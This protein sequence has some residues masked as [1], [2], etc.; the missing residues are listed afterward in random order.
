MGNKVKSYKKLK[1]EES[2]TVM[3]LKTSVVIL[4]K[5]YLSKFM[6]VIS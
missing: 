3:F 6:D 1:Y 2:N 4:M 5:N